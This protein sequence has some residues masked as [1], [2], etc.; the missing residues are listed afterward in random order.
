ML[1]DEKLSENAERMGKILREELSQIPKTQ[2]R[3]VRGRGLMC[4]IVVDDSEFGFF[5][6]V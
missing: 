4:A 5:V 3:T 1:L 2:I 6:N